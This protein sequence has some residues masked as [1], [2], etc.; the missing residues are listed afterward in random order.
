MDSF[1]G[2]REGRTRKMGRTQLP[3]VNNPPNLLLYNIRFSL[4]MPSP[5]G[6]SGDGFIYME[7]Q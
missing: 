3:A 6:R 1:K 2:E 4:V 7:L 5:W